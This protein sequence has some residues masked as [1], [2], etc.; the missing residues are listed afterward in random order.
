MTSVLDQVFIASELAFWRPSDDVAHAAEGVLHMAFRSAGS[1]FM[2]S[3]VDQQFRTRWPTR[4]SR[5]CSST[6]RLSPQARAPVLERAHELSRVD[7]A[8]FQRGEISPPGGFL[9]VHGLAWTLPARPG[10]R[11]FRP[12]R[13]T[14]TVLISFLNQPSSAGVAAGHGHHAERAYLVPHSMPPPS[15]QP[16]AHALEFR[17]KARR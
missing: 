13:V 3:L 10:M 17:P 1:L 12:L 2:S 6:W 4:A 7:H 9:H 16:A 14:A 8:A 15:V 11:I 5:W